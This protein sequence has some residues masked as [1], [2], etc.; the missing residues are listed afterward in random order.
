LPFYFSIQEAR[1]KLERL[2][3][4]MDELASLRQTILARQPGDWPLV[5]KSAGNG[6]SRRASRMVA[7]FERVDRLVHRIQED[8]VIL[9]DI[10][11]GLL[12]FPA[13]RGNHE[14]YLCWKYGEPELA[15]WH[16]VDAGFSGRQP[17]ETF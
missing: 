7:E 5:E 10:N 4:L 8:G 2:R 1:E 11:L 17:L 13:W 3:P 14:V 16:E 15:F 9:K 12:D 6:G